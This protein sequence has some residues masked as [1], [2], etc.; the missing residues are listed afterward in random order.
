MVLCFD[1]NQCPELL[2]SE[3]KLPLATSPP[4]CPAPPLMSNSLLSLGF[5]RDSAHPARPPQLFSLAFDSARR[6]L[7]ILEPLD[8]K[9]PRVL[10]AIASSNTTSQREE[11]STSNVRGRKSLSLR[12]VQATWTDRVGR[13]S[14]STFFPRGKGSK[15]RRLVKRNLWPCQVLRWANSFKSKRTCLA[16]GIISLLSCDVELLQN[17]RSRASTCRR[18]SNQLADNPVAKGDPVTRKNL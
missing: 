12:Q 3:T 2:S 8:R 1:T 5:C 4:E 14:R 18:V 16:R 13:H 9:S 17:I 11:L 15:C 7:E 10:G 6:S